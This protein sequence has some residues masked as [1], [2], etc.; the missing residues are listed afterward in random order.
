[1]AD[2]SLGQHWL[3]DK[4]TLQAIVDLVGLQPTDHCLEIGPG[5]GH[6]TDIIL[7][8]G[9]QVT[10]LEYDRELVTKLKA[11]YHQDQ[12]TI[13]F[14]DIRRFDLTSLPPDYKICANI[15]YYL[16]ANLFRKLTETTNK[17]ASA[18][19]LVQKEVALRLT[20]KVKRALLSILL[21]VSYDIEAGV[22][23]PAELFQPPPKVDSQ[24]I[25]LV[26]RP[27]SLVHPKDW[28][29][30][31]RLVKIGFASPRKQLYH[32]LAAGFQLTKPEA[33]TWLSSQGIDFS[34]RAEQLTIDQWLRLA[35]NS[36]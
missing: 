35:T 5:L 20:R 6:L 11:R 1:M 16:T 21:G 17:P 18:V 10:A 24:A 8:T 32:N 14:G 31:S 26:R 9:A 15:P 19:L 12:I 13:R 30:F 7:Q 4:P 2:K 36:P 29:A 23:V 22:L 33:K 27:Q 34:L 3:T 25:K 28:A